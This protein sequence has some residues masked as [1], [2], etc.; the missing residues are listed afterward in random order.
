MEALEML[1]DPDDES[2]SEMVSVWDVELV[3]D[4]VWD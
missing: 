4:T 2:V 1:L 3:S